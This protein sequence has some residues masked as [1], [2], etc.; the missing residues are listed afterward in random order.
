MGEKERVSGEIE[1]ERQGP[2][3]PVL[4]TVNPAAA[5][6]QEPKAGLHP[7]VYVAYVASRASQVESQ[8]E[9]TA[10]AQDMDLPLLVR[11]PVQQ[12]P[13]GYHEVPLPYDLPNH[14]CKD[15]TSDANTRLQPFS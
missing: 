3:A 7:A 2:E 9:L 8:Q 11:D 1:M 12:V 5:E 6:K 4:P 14:E 10:I 13:P 15:G